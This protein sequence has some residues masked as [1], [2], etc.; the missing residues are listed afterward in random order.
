MAQPKIVSWNVRGLNSAVKRSL[1]F[2]YLQGAAPHICILLETH[3]TGSR[4]LALRRA[5]VGAT[6]HPTYS[7]YSW[8][9]SV[10]VRKSLPFQILDV[11]TDPGGRYV[12]LHASIYDKR[13]VLVGVYLPPR[14]RYKY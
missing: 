14:L 13:L 9:V 4:V 10:L 12:I 8:G 2:R 6:Y 7:C 1:V 3:L 5:W 11:C